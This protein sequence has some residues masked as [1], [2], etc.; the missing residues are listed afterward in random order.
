[1]DWNRCSFFRLRV[2]M[3]EMMQWKIEI[4]LAL[5]R[6]TYQNEWDFNTGRF[7][8]ALC[9]CAFC[10]YCCPPSALMHAQFSFIAS[11]LLTY[12]S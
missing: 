5:D 1:M 6:E 11:A 7:A 8:G 12:R 2:N 4:D 9:S 10:I 3:S